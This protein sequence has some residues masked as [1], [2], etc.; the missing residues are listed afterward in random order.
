VLFYDGDCGLCNHSVSFVMARDRARVFAF[1]PLQGETARAVLG[2]TAIEQ[3]DTVVLVDALGRHQRSDAVL[4]VAWHLGG[5]WRLVAL[6][7]WVPRPLRD[8]A[9]DAVARRRKRWTGHGGQ[10]RLPTPGE[11]ERLLP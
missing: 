6:L 5:L 10:C 1:A 3:P 4:R 2:G 11:R 7:R 8:A 9:Y